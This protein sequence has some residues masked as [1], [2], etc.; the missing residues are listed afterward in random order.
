MKHAAGE[1]S[2]DRAGSASQ[3]AA[4]WEGPPATVSGITFLTGGHAKRSGRRA[5]DPGVVCAQDIEGLG[6]HDPRVN[7][8]KCGT[9]VRTFEGLL[10]IR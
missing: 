8:L 4:G 5:I 3:T 1:P 7:H 10:R 2:P 6:V 9:R